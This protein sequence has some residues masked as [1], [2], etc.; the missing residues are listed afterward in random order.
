MKKAMTILVLIVTYVTFISYLYNIERHLGNISQFIEEVNETV[1]HYK[2]LNPYHEEIG[3]VNV[4]G[5]VLTTSSYSKDTTVNEIG[6][7]IKDSEYFQKV[8]KGE[9]VVTEVRLNKK[10]GK[11][12]NNF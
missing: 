3:L 4:A 1:K 6:M 2:A 11:P 5:H 7:N 8:M 9:I 10:T 12:A